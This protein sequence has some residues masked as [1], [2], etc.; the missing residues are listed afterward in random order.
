MKKALYLITTALPLFLIFCCIA[1]WYV[2]MI[3]IF[4]IMLAAGAA[5]YF[6]IFKRYES[7][8]K[9][10]KIIIQILLWA[11]LIITMASPYALIY[12]A[13]MRTVE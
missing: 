11:A 13:I 8:S 9:R 4:P 1:M 10:T 3:V 5:W 7:L 6:L 12:F 2:G